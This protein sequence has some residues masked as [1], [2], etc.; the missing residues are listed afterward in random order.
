MPLDAG[1][2]SRAFDGPRLLAESG[3]AGRATPRAD[4]PGLEF[5][6]PSIEVLDEPS[7]RDFL[8]FMAASLA[9]GGVSGC[10]YQPDESIVPYVEAPE[11]IVPGKPLF[12]AS[13]IPID[14]YA[15]GVLVKSHMG[16]R[17]ISKA[18]RPIPRA[19]GRSTFS[20]RPRF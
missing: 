13:A 8:R 6:D 17:S 11:A 16:V 5:P 3:R 7:R 15:C 1:L 14:G 19:W 2:A 20:A 18:I 12:F 9:L 4:V 10:A